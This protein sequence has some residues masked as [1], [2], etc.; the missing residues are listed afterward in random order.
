[1]QFRSRK[2]YINHGNT[3]RERV[4]LDDW[5]GT[6]VNP[7]CPEPN[8]SR[9]VPPFWDTNGLG[10]TAL[11]PK[12]PAA[13]KVSLKI[14]DRR[15]GRFVGQNQPSGHRYSCDEFPPAS[16]IEGGDGVAGQG[17]L[18]GNGTAGN[19]YFAPLSA[20]CPE[21]DQRGSEQNWQG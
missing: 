4:Y 19:A 6:F 13:T 12:L 9:V 5:R 7:R 15:D 17:V 18:R 2:E 1:M 3:Q 16:F 14:A 8:Q 20:K 10:I 21:Y 11:A